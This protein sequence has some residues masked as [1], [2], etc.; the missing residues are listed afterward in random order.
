MG[1]KVAPTIANLVMA[2]FEEQFVYTYPL[3]PLVWFRFIDDNFMVWTHGFEELD[4]FLTH[5]NTCHP[6]IKFTHEASLTEAVFLDTRVLLDQDHKPY[7]TLYCKPTDTHCYLHFSS[8]HPKHQK[9]SGPYSQ[10]LRLRRIC[11]KETDYLMH[12]YNLVHSYQLRGYPID[13]L[14]NKLKE[15]QGLNRAT[16]LAP[17]PAPDPSEENKPLFCLTTY[18]PCNPPLKKILE[19]N[20]DIL[21]SDPTL[22]CISS[23]NFVVGH[24]RLPN[25]RDSLVHSRLRYPPPPPAP[26]KPAGW[27]NPDKICNTN[28]C[29]ICPMLNKSGHII[30]TSTD[31]RYIVPQHITCQFNNL[32]YAI[33]CTCCKKQY[34]GQTKRKLGDRIRQHLLDIRHCQDWLAA[35]PSAHAKGPTNVGLHFSHRGHQLSDVSVQIL[36]MIKHNPDSSKA[37]ETRDRRENY[38]IHK[39]RTIAPLGINAMDGSNHTRTRPNRI[40]ANNY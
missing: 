17:K 11:A 18:H 13:P 22:D 16:L 12:A 39:L 14:L 7:T 9:E 6:T 40:V 36:E 34:V 3:Q 21:G 31:F 24:R 25:V 20:R 10:F 37:K 15:V 26:P 33:T 30:S 2:D 32:I 38:W 19:Q 8:C 4:K 23:K 29:T 28:G 5:L 27:V 1:T 35:P